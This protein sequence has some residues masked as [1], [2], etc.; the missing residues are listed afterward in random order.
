MDP[1]STHMPLLQ[2]LIQH[3]SIG[4]VL[5]LGVGNHSTALFRERI[6]TVVSV[7]SDAKWAEKTAIPGHDVF[8][9][10]LLDFAHR[11]VVY[12][13]AFVDGN[14]AEERAAC[15]QALFGKAKVI[16]A[17]DTEPEGN[18][19]YHYDT[20]V[21]PS[22]FVRLDHIMPPP[23]PSP[24]KRTTHPWTSVFTDDA[25]TIRVVQAFLKR[26]A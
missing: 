10:S 5:E 14:P 2:W 1:Y 7:E 15:V 3:L 19:N 12:D 17:H 9:S 11:D 25:E 21:L 24:V 13:L 18:D 23:P 16:V 20:I 8:V 26:N 4:S 6:E 22:G